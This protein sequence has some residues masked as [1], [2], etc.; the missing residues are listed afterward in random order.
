MTAP[1]SGHDD[2]APRPVDLGDYGWGGPA[3]P[4]SDVGVFTT[5]ELFF[6][7]AERKY[8]LVWLTFLLLA[9]LIGA[10]VATAIYL[11]SSKSQL[12]GIATLVVTIMS[13]AIT[14]YFLRKKPAES[15]RQSDT[16]HGL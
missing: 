10:S 12:L 2:E 14:V 9:G 13:P 8:R 5:T 7:I 11:L 3:G 6:R 16:G 4:S 1:G 15:P